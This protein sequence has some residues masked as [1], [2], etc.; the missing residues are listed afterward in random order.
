VVCKQKF[1]RAG[2]PEVSLSINFKL[3]LVVVFN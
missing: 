1:L 2:K 3:V